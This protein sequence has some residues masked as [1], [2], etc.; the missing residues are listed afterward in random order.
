MRSPLNMLLAKEILTHGSLLTLNM[1]GDLCEDLL[2][3]QLD[4]VSNNIPNGCR[5]I[6]C[7]GIISGDPFSTDVRVDLHRVR[8]SVVCSRR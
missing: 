1:V 3:N 6:R 4:L 7:L 5:P 2:I 8:P